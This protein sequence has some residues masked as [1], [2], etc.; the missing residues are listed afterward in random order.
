MTRRSAPTRPERYRGALL[1]L[2]VGDAVGTTVEFAA[3]GTFELVADMV[4]GGPFGLKAGEWTDDAS[5]ALCL[6]ESLIEIG[7]F[8]AIDQLARYV[9]WWKEGHLSSN[10]RCFD[11]GNTVRSALTRFEQTGEPWCG[12]TDEHAAGNGS[13]MRVAPIALFF[14]SDPANAIELCY[15]EQAF[16]RNEPTDAFPIQSRRASITGHCESGAALR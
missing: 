2:A 8:D 13:L 1:G 16:L 15:P 6:A 10:G 3:P 9:R 4:G 5:M 14:A 11:I 12:S 7:H